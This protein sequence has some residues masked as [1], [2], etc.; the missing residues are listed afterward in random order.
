MDEIEA[1]RLQDRI[2]KKKKKKKGD[3]CS[4]RTKE[5]EALPSNEIGKRAAEL[6]R[7]EIY[8]S[9]TKPRRSTKKGVKRE[10]KKSIMHVAPEDKKKGFS[11][12][13]P[14]SL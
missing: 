8:I 4:K 10:V 7:V 14:A 12:T 1:Q 5:E 11:K 13:N 3:N 9:L 6:V 2:L